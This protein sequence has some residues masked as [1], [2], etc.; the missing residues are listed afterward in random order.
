MI[1]ADAWLY[2]LNNYKNTRFDLQKLNSTMSANVY[3]A[4]PKQDFQ[5]VI[6]RATKSQ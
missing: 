3:D 2:K 1:N 6:T 4:M 5:K